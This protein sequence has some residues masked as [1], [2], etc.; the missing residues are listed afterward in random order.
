MANKNTDAIIGSIKYSLDELSYK[1]TSATTG[2]TKRITISFDALRDM[3][4][5]VMRDIQTHKS[6]QMQEMAIDEAWAFSRALILIRK[7]EE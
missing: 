2:K 3:S 6:E 4:D 1:L 5:D 7:L